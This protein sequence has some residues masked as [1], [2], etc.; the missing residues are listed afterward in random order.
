MPEDAP[1]PTDDL[2]TLAR[3]VDSLAF[4][5]APVH[6]ALDQMQHEAP[7]PQK[8]LA[9]YVA[10][11]ILDL[12]DPKSSEEANYRRISSACEDGSYQ[13]SRVAQELLVQAEKL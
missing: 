9:E 4:H 11:L 5:A 12:W 8:K 1:S 3:L 6:T 10:A 2:K 7:L 13:L